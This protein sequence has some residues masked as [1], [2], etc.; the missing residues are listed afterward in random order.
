LKEIIMQL[1][2]AIQQIIKVP[3][4]SALLIG[5]PGVGKTNGAAAELRQAGYE[6]V[7]VNCQNMPV[8]DTAAL[9]IVDKKTNTTVFTVPAKFKA[10]KKVAFILDE[11]LKGTDEVVNSF[12]PLVHGRCFMDQQFDKDTP[13][14]IT[15]NSSEF[16]VG[17]ALRPHIV[18]RLI[19][20]EISDP[21][22]SEAERVMLDL[23]YDAR[24]IAWSQKVPH[25]LVSFDQANADKPESETEYY[26]G[27]RPRQPREPFCSMR[28]L[29]LASEYV[30]EGIVDTETLSGVI[31]R[32]AANS[33]SLFCREVG[34]RVD[35]VDILNGTAKVPQNL[36]DARM[37]GITASA[38]FDV[39]NFDA[40]LNYVDQLPNEIKSLVSRQISVKSCISDLI[41]TEPR[42]GEFISS[43]F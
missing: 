18:N 27:Y 21:T 25:A 3:S 23:K 42:V 4:V 15:A 28:S 17:D 33:L 10:R 5:S 22:A 19:R 24:I 30:K 13:V 41:G 39:T 11:L 6:V 12:M 7:V 40:V 2:R 1:N 43:N 34:Y 36:F 14:I 26:F 31:G 32:R 38:L 9:P 37:A 16:R 8:E 35:P 20:Y 29:E